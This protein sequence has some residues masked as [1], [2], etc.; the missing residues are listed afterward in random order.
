MAERHARRRVPHDLAD[1]LLRLA[2]LAMNGAILAIPLV[3][4]RA[5]GRS[6]Q[7]R[8]YGLAALRAEPAGVLLARM[9]RL[10]EYAAH[11]LEDFAIPSC[12]II[13]HRRSPGFVSRHAC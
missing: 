12:A 3:A 4:E 11:G 1:A 13:V 5:Y 6:R 10:A 9:V 2:A 8:L 7:R